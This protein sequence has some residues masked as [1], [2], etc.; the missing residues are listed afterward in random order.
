MERSGGDIVAARLQYGRL[1]SDRT[2]YLGRLLQ[3]RIRFK[4]LAQFPR[5]FSARKRPVRK[6]DD[7][8]AGLKLSKRPQRPQKKE[9]PVKMIIEKVNDLQKFWTTAKISIMN[10]QP[11]LEWKSVGSMDIV[12][13]F[14]VLSVSEK[15]EAN[16][17]QAKIQSKK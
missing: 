7:A 3:E 6:R 8:G 2:F 1:L 15:N 10:R 9:E 5:Y 12:S 17:K 4:L 11:G 16:K 14:H 13:F